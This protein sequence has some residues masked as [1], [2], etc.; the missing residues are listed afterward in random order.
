VNATWDKLTDVRFTPAKLHRSLLK[1][2][3]AGPVTGIAVH[4]LMGRDGTSL[5]LR[6]QP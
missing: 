6:G 1:G 4:A 3:I 2:N 5:T